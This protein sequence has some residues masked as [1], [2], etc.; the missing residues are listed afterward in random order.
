MIDLQRTLAQPFL[1][2]RQILSI[3]VEPRVSRLTIESGDRRC[4]ALF[5]QERGPERGCVALTDLKGL[6]IG[7]K[8]LPAASGLGR[9]KTNGVA[10]TP[11]DEPM[12]QP[13][14]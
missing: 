10:D 7:A 6:G 4:E 1:G 12:C 14:A 5:S 11:A 3:R 2:V 13:L 8:V 9:R